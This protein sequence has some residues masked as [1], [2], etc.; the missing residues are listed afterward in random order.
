MSQENDPVL[1]AVVPGVSSGV[2]RAIALQLASDPGLN[3]FGAH[4]GN[5]PDQANELASAVR[6]ADRRA[7]FYVGD[8][9]TEEGVRDAARHLREVAGPRSVHMFVHSIANAS[10]G[11]FMP[12]GDGRYRQL[13]ARNLHKTFDSMAHSF[14]WW[15]QELAALDLL[16]PGA[17]LLGLTNPIVDSIVNNFGVINAAKAALEV[18]VRHLALEMGPLGY[19]VNL[20][21]FGTV[22]TPAAAIGFGEHWDQFKRIC[23]QSTPAGRLLTGDEV[24]R[25]VST[26]AGEAGAWFN[27]ATIDMTGGQAQSILDA[28]LYRDVGPSNSER[29]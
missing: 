16:A 7:E 19:R 23:E 26:L 18:Y 22:E 29:R 5:Y 2:G 10:L 13:Q 14:V 6:D 24:A 1:W 8:A 4:R 21:N 15:A 3:V 17:R 11:R 20:L 25:F 12:G 27:G 28:A 9:G